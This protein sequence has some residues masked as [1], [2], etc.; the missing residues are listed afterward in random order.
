MKHPLIAGSLALALLLAVMMS[1]AFPHA[2]PSGWDYPTACCSDQDCAPLAA[3]AVR[4]RRGGWHVVVAPGTHP[5]VPAGSPAVMAFI[6]MAEAMKSP[7]GVFHI[8]LHP[9]D[10]RVLCFFTPLGGV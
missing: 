10:R 7:D 6:P 1:W 4:E 3:A 9:A 5:Q 8:C 2:A